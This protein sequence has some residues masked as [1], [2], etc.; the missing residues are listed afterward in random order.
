M[1]ICGAF[2]IS[3]W[4]TRT[5]FSGFA[6][7]EEKEFALSALHAVFHFTR[8]GGNVIPIEGG[9]KLRLYLGKNQV[10]LYRLGNALLLGHKGTANPIAEGCAEV[11]F[12]LSGSF[13]RSELVF[14]RGTY[15]L[16][17][18]PGYFAR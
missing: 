6:S 1:V 9:K 3:T 2:G 15:V 10:T 18:V 12:T 13:I 16:Q 11:S 4:C 5:V 7:I 14:G 8:Y 17:V